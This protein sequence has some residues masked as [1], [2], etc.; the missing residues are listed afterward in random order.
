M[1]TSDEKLLFELIKVALGKAQYCVLPNAF[2]W[3][4]LF[5]LSKKLHVHYTSNLKVS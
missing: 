2:D 5:E 1:I 3:N 4:V